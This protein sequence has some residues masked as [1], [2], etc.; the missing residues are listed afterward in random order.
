MRFYRK[1][2]EEVASYGDASTI[3]VDEF[4]SAYWSGLDVRIYFNGIYIDEVVN[5]QFQVSENV[6][7]IY[8][9]GDYEMRS[10]LRGSK[11]VQGAFSI[12]FKRSGYLLQVA[13]EVANPESG[14][15]PTHKGEEQFRKS[16]LDD[17][18]IEQYLKVLMSSKTS[19]GSSSGSIAGKI[20][21]NDSLINLE[22]LDSIAKRQS[23]KFWGKIEADVT[24]V[25]PPKNA[26]LI[27]TASGFSIIIRYGEPVGLET[28]Q[29]QNDVFYRYPGTV[30]IIRGVVL[31]GMNKSIDDSGRNILEVYSFIGSNLLSEISEF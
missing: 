11:S 9:Y 20:N 19:S 24:S 7:P 28:S 23:E 16:L 4:N 22:L 14:L 31:T 29:I 21:S 30:E 15:I 10:I 3:L 1:G 5:I 27:S 13:R 8:G 18:T 12:N 17:R 6:I 25:N 26:P 2:Y